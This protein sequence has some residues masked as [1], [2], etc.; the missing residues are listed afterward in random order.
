MSAIVKGIWLGHQLARQVVPQSH[1]VRGFFS[2]GL[3]ACVPLKFKCP[4]RT[5]ANSTR[6]QSRE[7][8][9]RKREKQTRLA[10][11]FKGPR[12]AS[13]CLCRARVAFAGSGCAYS[14]DTNRIEARHRFLPPVPLLPLPSTN[15]SVYP[16]SL[17]LFLPFSCSF[18]LQHLLL[19]GLT[20]DSQEMGRSCCS[21][22][23]WRVR[24]TVEFQLSRCRNKSWN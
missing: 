22:S 20:K 23:D 4:V 10:K 17:R 3:P 2:S 5:A 14:F 6:V 24:T 19:K 18:F 7:Q 8:R 15:L 12:S 11:G 16:P 1:R 9:K 13:V 21:S